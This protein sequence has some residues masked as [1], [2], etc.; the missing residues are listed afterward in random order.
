MNEQ[1]AQ[2]Y[3]HAYKRELSQKYRTRTWWG[4]IN[5]EEYAEWERRLKLWYAVCGEEYIG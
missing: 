1:D 2:N 4:K 5:R 3:F